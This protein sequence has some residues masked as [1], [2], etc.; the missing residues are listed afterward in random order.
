MTPTKIRFFS[1]SGDRVSFDPKP[2]RCRAKKIGVVQPK[3]KI[4]SKNSIIARYQVLKRLAAAAPLWAALTVTAA[5]YFKPK[6]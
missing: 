4:Y 6:V 1:F 2:K 3:P 5:T